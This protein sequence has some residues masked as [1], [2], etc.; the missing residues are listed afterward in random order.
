VQLTG[1]GAESP[2]P[3]LCLVAAADPFV[4]QRLQQAFRPSPLVVAAPGAD[5]VDR[6]VE[7][8]G[9]AQVGDLGQRF[10]PQLGVAVALH[11]GQQK[12]PAQLLGAVV[13]QHRAC[14]APVLR[15]DPRSGQRRPGVLLGVVEVLDRDPP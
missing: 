3:R 13:L 12:A 9:I 5:D 6:V 8:V 14:A 15:V 11:A 1:V 2:A 7:G 4:D 10:Q